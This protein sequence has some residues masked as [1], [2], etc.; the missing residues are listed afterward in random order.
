MSGKSVVLDTNI[1]V[2]HFRSK[3]QHDETFAK[4]E[5]FLPHVAIAELFAGAFKSERPNHNRKRL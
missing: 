1:V 2:A 4:R 3:K 5:L